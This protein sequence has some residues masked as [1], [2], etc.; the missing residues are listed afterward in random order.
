MTDCRSFYPEPGQNDLTEPPK[1]AC[2]LDFSD[3]PFVEAANDKSP[4]KRDCRS[5]AESYFDT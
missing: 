2:R 5:A 1:E 4:Q 3:I